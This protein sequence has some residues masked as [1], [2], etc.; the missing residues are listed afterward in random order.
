MRCLNGKKLSCARADHADD[1]HAQMATIYCYPGFSALF[2]PAFSGTR[3]A[4]KARLV[5]KPDIHI[6]AVEQLLKF[7]QKR[8][9]QLLILFVGP[10]I[11]IW[12]IVA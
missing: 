5:G 1:I 11:K 3:I 8:L 7:L 9:A 6:G 12:H 2:V 4:P 10:S